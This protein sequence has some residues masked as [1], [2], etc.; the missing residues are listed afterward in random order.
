MNEELNQKIETIIKDFFDKIG[1]S[2][3]SV[4][5]TQNLLY[6]NDSPGLFGVVNANVQVDA[7]VSLLL[8]RNG[9]S[10]KALEY[11]I[12]LILVKN[13]I[14]DVN[15]LVDLNDYKKERTEKISKLAKLVA[16]KVKR[17]HKS[18]VLFPM[19]SYERRLV[20]IEL[21]ADHE[22]LTESVGATPNRR[23]VI[24]PSR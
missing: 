13:Q 4:T 12:R 8:G 2:C 24:R 6:G 22:I 3:Q 11:L 9:E 7:D 15:L 21:A 17:N 18:E 20:H 16:E 5:L 10:L 14:M 1:Y 23:V 19:S